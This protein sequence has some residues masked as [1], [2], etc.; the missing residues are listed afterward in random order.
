VKHIFDPAK[1]D[2]LNNQGF[3]NAR[4]EKLYTQDHVRLR[5]YIDTL[6][7]AQKNLARSHLQTV[8]KIKGS[9]NGDNI[10]KT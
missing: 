6:T 8:L 9:K 7:E 5:E 10:R 1:C 2:F 3:I 4:V